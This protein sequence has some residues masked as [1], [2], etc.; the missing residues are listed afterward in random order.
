MF[1]N[2]TETELLVKF[3]ADRK[4]VK[5]Q[6]PSLFKRRVENIKYNP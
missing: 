1:L 3:I 4:G 6:V 5:N 2:S